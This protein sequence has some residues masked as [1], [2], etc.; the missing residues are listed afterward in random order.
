VAGVACDVAARL[1]GPGAA[2]APGDAHTLGGAWQFTYIIGNVGA[3]ARRGRI[4]LPV[5]AL[6]RHHV[7]AHE[8]LQGQYSERFTRLMQEQAERAHRLYGQ[9]LALLPQAERRAQK[10]SLIL[11]SLYRALLREIE[12]A[13]FQV[14]HQRIA[15][16]PL[17]K[18][19]LAWKMQALGRL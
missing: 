14:L 7:S 9:A 4:Y 10:P 6:Q 1:C 17:R 18:L 13:Q 11:A 19:W 5:D 16:T 15:L 3:H 2:P 8:I 12:A